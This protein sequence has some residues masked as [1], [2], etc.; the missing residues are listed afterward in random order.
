MTPKPRYLDII[1]KSA[2]NNKQDNMSLPEPRY[3]IT[4]S[5]E[6][7]NI[8]EAQEKDFKTNSMKMIEILKE[9]TNKI[10]K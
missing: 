4:A 9:E 10:L 2:N 3:P 6:N 5:T 7:S 1:P 8:A